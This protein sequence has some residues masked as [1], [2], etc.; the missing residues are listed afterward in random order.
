MWSY[1]N[2]NDDDGYVDYVYWNGRIA[3]DKPRL[4]V[5][6]F[7]ADGVHSLL[8]ADAQLED[9]GQ[10]SCYDGQGTRKA[11]YRLAGVKCVLT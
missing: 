5:K 7:A 3:G 8:I 1:D 11:G 9:S 10:Y 4:S 6:K 2:D